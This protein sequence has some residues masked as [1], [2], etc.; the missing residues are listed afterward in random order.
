MET[1]PTEPLSMPG[2]PRPLA[3]LT[4]LLLAAATALG[5]LAAPA[6][7][8]AAP[9]WA[10]PTEATI[11]PGVQMVTEGSQC[12]ANFVFTDGAEIYLGYAAHCAGTGEATATD[13]CEAGTLPTGTGVDIEGASRPGTLAYSSWETMQE[14]GESDTDTCRFNDFALVALHPDDHDAVNPTIPFWGGPVGLGEST[15]P[16]EKVYTY[17]N[18]SLRLGVELLKPKEGYS[19]GQEPSGWSHQ[20]YTAT[21]GIPGDSGSAVLDSTGHAVGALST[22]AIAPL[23]GSNG[24]TDLALALDYAT[25]HGDVA[26]QLATG[27]EAFGGGLVLP[28][29]A[30]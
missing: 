26:A 24:V 4:L 16:L 1:A 21:P 8:E 17:G 20:V 30:P 5:G 29:L 22:L 28:D 14:R 19:L 10:G 2:T 7:A 12:T 25:T 15:A 6:A 18:S 23:A 9:D 3:A 27:T 13:G 11:T